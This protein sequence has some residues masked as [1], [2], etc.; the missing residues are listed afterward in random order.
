MKYNLSEIMKRAWEVTRKAKASF[1]AALKFSWACAKKA[2]QLKVADHREDIPA[3]EVNFTIW[4]KYGK[5]RAYY[6]C[7]WWSK[8]TNSKPYNF[9]EM[10]A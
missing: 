9:V 6:K 4:A 10:G 7:N 8:Y 2:L 1:T 3:C 5:V